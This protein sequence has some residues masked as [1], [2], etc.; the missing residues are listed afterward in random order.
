[1]DTT[2]SVLVVAI[3]GVLVFLFM[4]S[5]ANGESNMEPDQCVRE[6]VFIEC[7]KAMSQIKVVNGD[8]Q[9]LEDI[10]E[11]CSNSA[12]DISLRNKDAIPPKCRP[13]VIEIDTD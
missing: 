5:P 7:V 4:I 2:N 12:Y 6:R 9:D 10:V 8:D 13:G 1:M 11:E 3:L